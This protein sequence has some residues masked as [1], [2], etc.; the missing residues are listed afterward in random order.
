MRLSAAT[1]PLLQ[2]PEPVRVLRASEARGRAPLPSAPHVCAN[3]HPLTVRR[4]AG[5]ALERLLVEPKKV[6]RPEQVVRRA[7]GRRPLLG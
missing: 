1:G 3:A 4:R 7:R 2:A 5:V 6:G